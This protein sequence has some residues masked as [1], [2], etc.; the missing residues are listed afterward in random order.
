MAESF[1]PPG[2]PLDPELRAALERLDGLVDWER[3]ER[4]PG[5]RCEMRV[6]LEPMRDLCARLGHP[7]RRFRA[8]HVAG[9]KGKGSVTALLQAALEAAGFATGGY[10]SP[11]VERV[12][13]RVLLRA[14]PIEGG[15]LAGALARA[16]EARELGLAAGTPAVAATWFDVLTAAAFLAL[17]EARVEWAVV[18]CGLG[19]RLDS[20]NVLPP[21]PC[22]LTNV[23][24]EHTAI[25]GDTRAAIAAEKAGIVKPGGLLVSGVG[26]ATDE[27]GAIVAA[28]AR[29]RG[30]P[31]VAV[32]PPAAAFF[33]ERNV[34]LAGALLEVLGR[35]GVLAPRDQRPLGRRLLD[36]ETVR[37]ARL[38]GRVETLID[39]GGDG[40][41]GGVKVVLDG[42]H[43]PSSAALLMR[44]LASRADLPGL[45]V[46][47]LGLGREKDADGFL[48]ELAGRVDRVLCTRVGSGPHR[49]PES[50]VEAA[51]RL[52]IE[53]VA[54]EPPEA[55][56]ARAR[57][58]LRPGGWVLVT[59]SLHLVGALRGRIACPPLA[60]TR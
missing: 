45:P 16:F 51:R 19:G 32:E 57:Q 29:E 42:A 4:A 38:P 21:G 53:A 54:V 3:R 59:G 9:T 36:P 37:A 6:D 2:R 23:D 24:L 50:L 5:G 46:V 31:L 44:E 48:K 47:I 58:E 7:E 10:A 1:V 41:G 40:G 13:E 8:I 55:A 34:A 12:E 39:G 11:H 15:V 28:A 20:T 27:A 26:P 22:L 30:V 60:T 18:E 33:E 17:A 56:Y 14:R 49:D 52:G 43:V 25:L 35:S